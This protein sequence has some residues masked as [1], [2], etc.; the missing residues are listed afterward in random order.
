VLD[1]IVKLASDQDSEGF[2]IRV[3]N[4]VNMKTIGAE[5]IEMLG[6]SGL[7]ILCVYNGNPDTLQMA[8]SKAVCEF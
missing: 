7:P 6:G 1:S 4:I 2:G 5:F 8:V 3:I